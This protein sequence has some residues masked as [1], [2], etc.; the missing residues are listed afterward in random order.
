MPGIEILNTEVIVT[1]TGGFD[2]TACIITIFFC[3]LIG[4]IIGLTTSLKDYSPILGLILGILIGLIFGALVGIALQKPIIKN[5]E[6]VYKVIISDEVSFN[7][8]YKKYEILQK[9]G[10]IYTITERKE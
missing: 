10:K 9:E 3:A 2:V 5:E 4:F 6:V 1:E 7:E 8:F